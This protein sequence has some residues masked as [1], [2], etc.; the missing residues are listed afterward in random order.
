MTE[1]TRE[2]ISEWD[3]VSERLSLAIERIREIPAETEA[4]PRVLPFFAREAVYIT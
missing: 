4:D 3:S 1:E 2:E